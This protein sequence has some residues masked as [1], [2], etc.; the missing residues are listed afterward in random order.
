MPS[1]PNEP[2]VSSGRRP[3]VA[4]QIGGGVDRVGGHPP[5]GGELPAGDRDHAA[6]RDPHGVAAREV[7]GALPLERS[8]GRSPAQVPITSD[9][10]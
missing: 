8:N 4:E 10:R 7:G 3:R 6:R 5:V 9:S 2:E 1:P